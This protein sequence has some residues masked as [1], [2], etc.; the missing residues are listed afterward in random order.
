[1]PLQFYKTGA[2]PAL[3][4]S[5]MATS[6]LSLTEF[7][8]QAS[9]MLSVLAGVIKTESVAALERVVFRATRGNAVFQQKTVKTKLLDTS[10]KVL[11]ATRTG[12][13]TCPAVPAPARVWGCGETRGPSHWPLP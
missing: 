4:E 3:S 10:G 12:P 1:L 11:L 7:G 2:A 5:D 6:L 13:C 8:G 9:S